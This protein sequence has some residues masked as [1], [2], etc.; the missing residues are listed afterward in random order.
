VWTAAGLPAA[1]TQARSPPELI[2]ADRNIPDLDWIDGL[3]REG[4]YPEAEAA[5]RRALS[6]LEATGRGKTLAASEYADR[7]V[8]VLLWSAKGTRQET[9]DRARL[10]VAIK[11]AELGIDSIET[12]SSLERLGRVLIRTASFIEASSV[13]TRSLAIAQ[14]AGAAYRADQANTQLSLGRLLCKQGLYE[15]G[16]AQLVDA[17]NIQ[18]SAVGENSAE[19]ARALRLIGECLTEKR[20]LGGIKYLRQA[21]QH[22]ESV[23][24]ENHPE[25]AR[26][27]TSLGFLLTLDGK[28]PEARSSLERALAIYDRQFGVGSAGSSEALTWLGRLF[29]ETGEYPAAREAFDQAIAIRTGEYGPFDLATITTLYEWSGLLMRIG[30]LEEGAVTLERVASVRENLLGPNHPSLADAL[31]LRGIT[32]LMLGDFSDPQLLA[33]AESLMLRALAIR[34]NSVG[35]QSL[36]VA[37][38]MMNLA[39]LLYEPTGNYGKALNFG[40]HSLEILESLPEPSQF[41]IF[42]SLYSLTVASR[43]VGD[44]SAAL[45]YSERAAAIREQVFGEDHVH[46]AGILGIRAQLLAEAGDYAAMKDTLLQLDRI[47]RN[48]LELV[49]RTA[50]ENEAL[51]YASTMAHGWDLLITFA[52]G[53]EIEPSLAPVAWDDVVHGRGLILDEMMTRRRIS[54]QASDPELARLWT[55]VGNADRHLAKLVIAGPEQMDP[56]EFGVLVQE[57]RNSKKIAE[58]TFATASAEYR[59]NLIRS[60]TGLSDV[61]DA[62]PPDTALVAFVKYLHYEYGTAETRKPADRGVPSY[63]AFVI[64]AHDRPPRVIHLGDAAV[65]D[66]YVAR[67]REAVTRPALSGGRISAAE[68]S[69]RAVA[70]DLRRVVWDPVAQQVGNA[71]HVFVVPEGALHAVNFAALP[72]DQSQYVA[73]TGPQIHYLS[74]ERDVLQVEPVSS[75]RGLLALGAPDF[76]ATGQ[77]ASL[78]GESQHLAMAE[79]DGSVTVYRGSRSACGRFQSMSFEPLQ[80]SMQEVTTIGDLWRQALGGSNNSTILTGV[81]ASETAFKQQASNARVLHLATHGFFLGGDC[82]SA[83]NPLEGD[84]VINEN[85]LLLSG[86]VLAGANRRAAAGPNEDDGILTAEEIATLDLSATEWVVLSACDTGGGE[87]VTGE[88][89]FGL[90]R[91]FR[92]AGARTLVMSLWPVEDEVARDWMT[93]LY[94]RHFID[95]RS[96]MEAAHDASI[97]LLAGRRA[98]GLSTHPFYWA[99]FIAS[100]DWR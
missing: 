15:A 87:I 61:I 72:V 82:G 97:Q 90:Q 5:A 42:Y 68:A 45:A 86:L 84:D 96:T 69:Y 57:A 48:H 41:N 29:G 33:Q 19:A 18:E 24:N 74:S 26:I 43:G 67:W 85:P 93:V 56:N 35:P 25:I 11:E 49:V 75:D 22:M 62:L 46:S 65:I 27:L 16:R 73:D 98:S 78:H 44:L 66:E 14:R 94:R 2:Q 50:S 9:L 77:Y 13:L 54:L 59:R 17:L 1:L 99:G 60:R 64:Q 70:A 21:L 40:Q 76:D 89:V 12:A 38:S 92:M 81:A 31:Q 3:I 8:D 100:G 36:A 30:E 23:F 55:S 79:P 71:G 10:A 28:F 4:R 83:L 34:S 6:R 91:A 58:R 37:N 63:A 20:D 51:Q 47:G 7:L 52:G 88:G 80:A 32:L 39:N 95:G 53:D